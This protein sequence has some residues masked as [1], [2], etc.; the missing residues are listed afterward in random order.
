MARA[1]VISNNSI[2]VA[3]CSAGRFAPT[4][5][6]VQLIQ[7]IY[8]LAPDEARGI[9]RNRIFLESMPTDMCVEMIRVAAKRWSVDSRPWSEIRADNPKARVISVNF[10]RTY[11]S[12]LAG[13]LSNEIR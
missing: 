12:P 3:A 5:P 4:S 11:S 13:I 6:T 10:N 2:Y 1:Y 9:L 8:E 7:G